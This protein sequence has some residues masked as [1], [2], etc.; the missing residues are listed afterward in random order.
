MSGILSKTVA[1][2]G[3]YL[4][5]CTQRILATN[6][7]IRDFKVKTFLKRRCVHCYFVRVDGRMHVEC[8]V[9]PRH[10]T[11]EP[12]N[13]MKRGPS[14][15]S[16]SKSTALP[17]YEIVG[18]N[19]MLPLKTINPLIVCK[20]CNGYFIEATTVIECVHT[21]CRSCLLKHFEENDNNCPTCN[22][23]IHQ[24]YPSQYVAFDR[25]MQDIVYK[26]VPGL[27]EEE[28][29]RVKA[30]NKKRAIEN[31]ESYEEDEEVEK[32]TVVH[33]CCSNDDDLLDCHKRDHD[34]VG[35]ELIAGENLDKLP[36]NIL[37]VADSLTV[38]SLK[39]YVACVLLKDISKYNEFDFF[40]NNE[41]MGRDFTLQFISRSRWRNKDGAILKLTYRSCVEY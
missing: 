26:L 3:Y 20:L 22:L 7:S 11:R 30:F 6:T 38:S 23:E 27:Y 28:Q 9:S 24:C 31:G 21:F 41:L 34:M 17:K 2:G 19:L 4:R 1:T 14:E 12:F 37:R 33:A 39:R 8:P 29:K 13:D 25:T 40:C 15:R 36:R 32:E 10:K 5:L 35:V 18:D 16:K